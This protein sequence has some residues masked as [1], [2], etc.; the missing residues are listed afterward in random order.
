MPLRARGIALRL[1]AGRQPR[2]FGALSCVMLCYVM[3][4]VRVFVC[5]SARR[6]SFA[7]CVVR[8]KGLQHLRWRRATSDSESAHAAAAAAEA[9]QHYATQTSPRPA[10]SCAHRR[11][12]FTRCAL[13]TRKGEG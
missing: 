8:R 5:A 11:A 9:M 3:C 6:F 12:K 2:C 7:N 13:T 10:S 4:T 1:Q